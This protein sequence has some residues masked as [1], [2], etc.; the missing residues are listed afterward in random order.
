MTDD[1]P[2]DPDVDVGRDRRHRPTP[3]HLRPSSLAVVAAGGTVGTAA[4]E[5]I[6]LALPAVGGLPVAIFLINLCGAFLLGVL[7]EALA[8]RGPD[9][10]RRRTLRLLLGT[11]ALGGFT[12]YSAFAADTAA[13]VGSGDPGTAVLYVALTLVVGAVASAAGIAVAGRLRRRAE[14]S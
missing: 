4:R 12:T 13:L 10:G 7:L 6:T 11:G 8:R 5:A 9:E 14:A 1:L 2:L 3:V